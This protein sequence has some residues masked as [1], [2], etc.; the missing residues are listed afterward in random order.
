MRFRK[1]KLT[2]DHSTTFF[3]VWKAVEENVQLDDIMNKISESKSLGKIIKL[4]YSKV[5]ATYLKNTLS[6][7]YDSET[8]SPISIINNISAG[9]SISPIKNKNNVPSKLNISQNEIKPNKMLQ[10]KKT[11]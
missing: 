5:L 10:K 3:S 11:K 8:N 7:G 6:G 1:D 4:D 2:A 9:N